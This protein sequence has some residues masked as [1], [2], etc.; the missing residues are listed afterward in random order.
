MR[1]MTGEEFSSKTEFFDRMVRTCWLSELHEKL[2]D[3]SGDWRGKKVLDIGC[4][5]GRLLFRGS[6]DAVL[7]AGID[8]SPAMITKAEMLTPAARKN[9]YS[10]KVADAYELPYKE[11][12]FDLSLSTCVIFLLPDPRKALLEMARVTKEGGKSCLLNPGIA[13]DP[14]AAAHYASR[15]HFNDEEKSFLEAWADV[16]PRRHRFE[17]AA[18]SRLLFDIGAEEVEQERALD[19]L[20]LLTTIIWQ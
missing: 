2:M 4:G 10:F 12:E 1:K 8:L 19:G 13:M 6:R 9:Q 15:Q 14:A 11:N 5:T 7:L 20:A 16:S 17:E 18:F 3:K